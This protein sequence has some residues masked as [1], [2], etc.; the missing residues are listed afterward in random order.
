[1]EIFQ[2]LRFKVNT[3]VEDPS[4]LSINKRT[5]N[6][7]N[8]FDDDLKVAIQAHDIGMNMRQAGKNEGCVII[9]KSGAKRIH[10]IVLDQRKWLSVLVCINAASSSIPSFYIFKG[11]RFGPNYIQQCESG[12]TM[13]MQPRAWMTSYLVM[14]VILCL[15]A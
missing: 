15:V 14:N 3:L 13:V 6:T 2:T 1:M 12:A 9:A 4:T 10:S 5:L 7:C 11:K 8:W